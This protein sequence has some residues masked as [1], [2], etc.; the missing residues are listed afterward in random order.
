MAAVALSYWAAAQSLVRT[1]FTAARWYRAPPPPPP[2]P[3]PA[4]F[5]TCI[6]P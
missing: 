5:P 4:L 2:P 6:S 3:P 1:Q